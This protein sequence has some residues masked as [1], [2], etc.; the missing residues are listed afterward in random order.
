M[1][2]ETGK[3]KMY[4]PKEEQELSMDLLRGAGFRPKKA[5]GEIETVSQIWD[6]ELIPEDEQVMRVSNSMGNEV[7]GLVGEFTYRNLPWRL[8]KEPALESV[9]SIEYLSPSGPKE[10]M[11]VVGE[12]FSKLNKVKQLLKAVDKKSQ[13]GC[14]LIESD[15]PA[16]A[17]SCLKE[18][19]GA[20]A[21]MLY[22]PPY[23]V[24]ASIKEPGYSPKYFCVPAVKRS[25]KAEK[26]GFK[27]LGTLLIEQKWYFVTNPANYRNFISE[28]G[29][30]IK[31][32]V[33]RFEN[34]SLAP[35]KRDFDKATGKYLDD[36]DYGWR[37][38]LW[39]PKRL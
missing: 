39:G 31:A 14:P 7:L 24:E 26:Y 13:V 12:E 38:K 15:F 36:F 10:L 32:I 1:K 29:S 33:R 30:E 18:K 20:K 16:T 17:K 21:M 9:G 34:V 5:D 3:L 2:N 37:E 23:S 35:K 19:F 8:P 4:L 28:T 6:F 27:E 25:F 22:Q 11:V